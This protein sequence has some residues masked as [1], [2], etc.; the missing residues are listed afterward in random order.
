MW[1]V[2]SEATF[3]SFEEAHAAAQRV[4]AQGHCM[5]WM[6]WGSPPRYVTAGCVR[7]GRELVIGRTRH[8]Q[9]RLEGTALKG[10]VPSKVVYLEVESHLQRTA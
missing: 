6:T 3:G 4:A 9:F 5:Q 7:C 10:C 1:S 8:G 2:P